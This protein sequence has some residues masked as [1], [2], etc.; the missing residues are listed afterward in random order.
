MFNAKDKK[1]EFYDAG[2]A[3]NAAAR[4]DRVRWLEKHLQLKHIDQPALEGIP[5]LK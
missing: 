5:Q 1:M 4:V 2:P 3:L